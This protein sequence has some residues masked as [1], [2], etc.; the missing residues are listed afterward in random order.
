MTEL[1][2][3]KVVDHI[4]IGPVHLMG[5]DP[6]FY[7]LDSKEILDISILNK[8]HACYNTFLSKFNLI[9]QS[10]IFPDHISCF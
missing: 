7:W 6:S 1:V 3:T 10:S 8:K 5:G 9:R 4:P 2:F